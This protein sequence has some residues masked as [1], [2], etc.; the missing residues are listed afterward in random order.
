MSEHKVYDEETKRK[1]RLK[2]YTASIVTAIILAFVT[3]VEFGAAIFT[4]S[5]VIMMLLGLVKAYFVVNNF[6]HVSR[7]WSSD[8]GH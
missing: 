8:G 2:A 7:L 3:I 6:M 4:S 5:A 1:R